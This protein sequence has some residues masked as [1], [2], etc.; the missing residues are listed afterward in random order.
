MDTSFLFNSEEAACKNEGPSI[1]LTGF[2]FF[3]F[4][5]VMLCQPRRRIAHP[6]IVIDLFMDIP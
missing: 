3:V 2:H 5:K 6:G 1:I 4:K